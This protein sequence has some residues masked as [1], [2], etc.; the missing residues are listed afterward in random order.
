LT[1]EHDLNM[2]FV[3]GPGHGGP[4][5]IANTYLEESYTERYPDI[6]RNR[7]RLQRLFC[8]FGDDLL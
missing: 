8:Q 3:T 1:K 5:V 7:Y 6:E 2:I 4:G